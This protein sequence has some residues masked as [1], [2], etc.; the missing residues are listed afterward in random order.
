MSGTATKKPATLE[1]VALEAGVT[2]MTVSR[3]IR[4]PD[5]VASSTRERIVRAI[6][7]VGYVQNAYASRL[8][9]TRRPILCSIVPT[10]EVSYFGAVL[11]GVAEAADRADAA[12]M[13]G[14]TNYDP[15][16]QDQLFRDF[17]GWHPHGIIHMADELSPASRTLVGMSGSRL[18]EAWEVS[19]DAIDSSVGFSNRSAARD[20]TR[21]LMNAG[22]KN[23]AFAS[24]KGDR[25]RALLRRIGYSDAIAERSRE[26]IVFETKAEGSGYGVGADLMDEILRSDR[27]TDA[28]FFAGDTLGVGAMY[29]AIRRGLRVPEEIAI[30]GFGDLDLSCAIEPG[31]TTVR[32]PNAAIGSRCVE[33]ILEPQRRRVVDDLGFE[34]VQRGSARL[35]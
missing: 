33:I 8:A 22:Y 30:A 16:R 3:L 14:E 19:E 12:L 9:G 29:Q 13:I 24:R 18:V 35:G 32:V 10:L 6:A 26:Q 20:L 11:R 21:A 7:T 17:L 25:G 2:P 34:L 4:Q 31:L 28:V 15:D 1:D 27:T 23:V 5:K